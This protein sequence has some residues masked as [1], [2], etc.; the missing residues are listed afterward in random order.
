MNKER[1]ISNKILYDLNLKNSFQ[2]IESLKDE[3]S[4]FFNSYDD[5]NDNCSIFERKSYDSFYNINND[6]LTPKIENNFEFFEENIKYSQK[7]FILLNQEINLEMENMKNALLEKLK[8]FDIKFIDNPIKELSFI[9]LN[10]F[11]NKAYS[12]KIL[13][14]DNLKIYK[15]LKMY[16]SNG[17]YNGLILSKIE[18]N[19]FVIEAAKDL[20]ENTLLFEIGG[21]VVS[22]DYLIKYKK[23]LISK[24]LCYFKYCE[25]MENSKYFLL[26][27]NYGNI[28]FFCKIQKN[29]NL[30]SKLKIL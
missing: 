7:K 9:G 6:F 12:P 16:S 21:E 29:M 10:T 25:G 4:K 1:T 3:K 5:Y 26:L 17:Y 28:A 23:D 2:S 8:N 27:R 14:D 18:E 24:N 15:N 19:T 30:M 20:E 22:K 11:T 13:S